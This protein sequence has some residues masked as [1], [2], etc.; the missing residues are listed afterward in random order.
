MSCAVVMKRKRIFRAV[1]VQMVC[2]RGGFAVQMLF[3]GLLNLSPYKGMIL[4]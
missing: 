4:M 1:F 3:L 2:R